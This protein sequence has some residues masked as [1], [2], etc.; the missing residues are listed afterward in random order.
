LV[1]DPIDAVFWMVKEHLLEGSLASNMSTWDKLTNA[2]V[3]FLSWL[4]ALPMPV[5][6]TCHDKAETKG[7]VDVISPFVQGAF[8]DQLGSFFDIILYTKVYKGTNNK[9]DFKWQLLPDAIRP[10]RVPQ[11]L[12]KYGNEIGGEM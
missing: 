7:D 11:S 12:F 4:G 1:I 6:A 5:I 10:T 3:K 2:S 9:V 8:K